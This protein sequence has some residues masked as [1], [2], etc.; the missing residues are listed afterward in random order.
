V[1]WPKVFVCG[2]GDLMCLS[3]FLLCVFIGV[4]LEVLADPSD[5]WLDFRSLGRGEQDK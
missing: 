4:A 1:C 3:I 5:L 2:A